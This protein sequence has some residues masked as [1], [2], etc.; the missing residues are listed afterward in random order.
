MLNFYPRF[1]S[2]ERKGDLI[3]ANYLKMKKPFKAEM[4]GEF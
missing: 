3:S 2:L 4:G 1:G